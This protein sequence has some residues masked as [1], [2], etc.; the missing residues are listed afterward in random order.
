MNTKKEMNIKMYIVYFSTFPMILLS[1]N[2]FL[3][4]IDIIKVHQNNSRTQ[5]ISMQTI[6]LTVL[7]YFTLNVNFEINIVI[8]LLTFELKTY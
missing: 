7:F 2:I 3:S 8:F 6:N 5:M 4:F 1:Q